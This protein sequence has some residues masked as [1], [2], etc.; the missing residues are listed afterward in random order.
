MAAIA[1]GLQLA[2]GSA[3]NHS[4]RALSVPRGEAS[5]ADDSA[6]N[7]RANPSGAPES[8]DPIHG[9]L[10]ALAL[11]APLWVLLTVWLLT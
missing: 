9:F 1:D 7:L 11:V 10:W 4:E 5:G 8:G 3:R 2:P 6:S